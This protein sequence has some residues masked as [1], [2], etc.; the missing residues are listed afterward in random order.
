MVVAAKQMTILEGVGENYAISGP[1]FVEL[2]D[3]VEDTLHFPMPFP[4]CLC[5]SPELLAPEIATKLRSRRK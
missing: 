1:K 5:S 2:W 3:N 4:N